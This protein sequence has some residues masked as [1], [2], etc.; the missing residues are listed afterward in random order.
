M[1][2]HSSKFK[3]PLISRA[4][5][6][7]L[8]T[9]VIEE[10]LRLAGVSPNRDQVIERFMGGA[11]RIAVV[12]GST[13][14]PPAIGSK[15]IA[16]RLMRLIWMNGAI[17]FE[18]VQSFPC[19]ELS[20][21]TDGAHYALLSR[22]L[23]T[24]S[25][26]AHIEEHGY[27]AAVVIGV[28]DKMMVGNLRALIEADLSRQRRRSRPFFAMLIPSLVGRDTYLPDEDRRRLELLKPKLT[29]NERKDLES[30]LQ[31]PLRPDVYAAIKSLVDHCFHRRVIQEDERDELERNL[32]KCAGVPGANC[33]AS[34]ASMVHRMML[35]SFGLVPRHLDILV[36]L[37][38]ENQL[39]EVIKRLITAV[40][41]RERRVSVGSLTRSNLPN[42]AAVWSATGGH[43]GWLMHLSYI[44]DAIGKK[45]TMD[46]ITKKVNSIPQ[47]LAVRE[48]SGQSAYMMG[49][50]TENGGNSG[51]DTIM[52]TLAEKRLIEDRAPTIDGSWM[53]RI[54][55][56][57]SANG[58]FVYSTM[59]PFSATCGLLNVRG[60]VCTRAV[61]RIGNG[62]TLNRLDKKLFLAVH[63]L[64]LK[65]LQAALTSNEGVLH[66]LKRRIS[67][68]DLYHT[69][70]FNWCSPV[71]N[72]SLPGQIPLARISQLN[73]IPLWDFLV[74]DGYL[75]V[76]IIV[77]GVGPR[78]AGM[79]EIPITASLTPGTVVVTDGRITLQHD[80]IAISQVVPEAINDGPLAAVRTGDW[81][82]MDLSRK[83]FHV[84]AR[85]DKDSGYRILSLKELL[86]RSDFK[87]RV[88][89]LQR[90]QLDFIPSVR[91]LMDHVSAA[92][93]GVSPAEK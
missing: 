58:K 4:E 28:C 36:K 60:N 32:A 69:A 47:I 65:D 88:Q 31:R 17:P 82:Y 43:P 48:A 10:A 1:K 30:W 19:E 87:K 22:N 46:D 2:M 21:W 33:G 13:D 35:A 78:A 39:E 73:K 77:A 83:E 63:Y 93:S 59:N 53:H 25:M 90:Q 27:D 23:C 18:V 84:V 5:P 61:A 24:A 41:K 80:G 42:A 6:I 14:H 74:T 20:Q 75:R 38:A 67:R 64:G 45:L 44:A 70:V 55:D 76:M 89:E 81:I 52:R 15:D 86:S 34:E 49:V 62:D 7:T 91:I 40:Q 26:A 92:D 9:P 8:L 66:R 57:R 3:D 68:E 29:E 56:A 11:P 85:S 16:R 79:P 71:G 12:C 72:G 51:I 37:P 54:M 50:E